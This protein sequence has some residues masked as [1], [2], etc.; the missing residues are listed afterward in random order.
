MDPAQQQ[1]RKS[2]KPVLLLLLVAGGVVAG[3]LLANI[4]KNDLPV[5]NII[6]EGN[7]VVSTAEV[8]KLAKL[9]KEQ[10]LF[11]VDLFEVRRRLEAH[12]FIR[13]ASVNREV[14]DNIRIEITEREP[15]AAVAMGKLKYLDEEGFV[16]PPAR[17]EHLFDLPVITGVFKAADL[18]SGK[19]T[20]RQDLLDA[21]E[22]ILV[23]KQLDEELYHTISE[24]HVERGKDMVLYSA[25]Y[26]VP[27]IFG[28]DAP[29][30][31]LLK[32]DAFWD[33]F[34][35]QHGVSALQYIDVRYQDQVIDR[36]KHNPDG[37]EDKTEQ[38]NSSTHD[39]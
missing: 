29:A 7:R 6:V 1:K 12:T 9:E 36:R 4:W 20:S 24:V 2:K 33:S 26:G 37:D 13:T 30:E 18:P 35:T 38:T 16:L 31:K 10:N 28:N 5:H 17:S 22:L 23:A 19:K 39:T 34:V 3:T 14:P 32:L 27:V 11:S 21:L 15:V 25:E 8:L